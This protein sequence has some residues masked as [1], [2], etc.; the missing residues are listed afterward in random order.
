MGQKEIDIADLVGAY[1]TC[2]SCGSRKVVRDAWAEWNFAVGEWALK[3]VFDHHACDECGEETDPVWKL[4]QE[5]RK[6]RIRRLNDALRRGEGENATIVITSGMQAAGDDFVETVCIA[7]AGFDQFSEDNDPH[8]E[9]DF[10]AIEINGEKLFW[11]IDYYDQS[12]TMLSP[13]PANPKV[14]HRVLTI[15]LASEY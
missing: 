5:L 3:T 6:K 14:T 7:V 4:D 2:G 1:P 9:H 8:K 13:D 15:M 10:G 11:K 12:M